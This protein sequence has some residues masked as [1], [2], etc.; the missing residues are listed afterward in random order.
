MP[1]KVLSPSAGQT[2]YRI[3]LWTTGTTPPSDVR[4]EGS[5]DAADLAYHWAS[6]F[7][8]E[9]IRQVRIRSFPREHHEL[10]TRDPEYGKPL[11]LII[12][13]TFSSFIWVEEFWDIVS[14]PTGP[15][16]FQILSILRSYG[17]YTR[18]KVYIY[19]NKNLFLKYYMY[20]YLFILMHSMAHSIKYPASSIYPHF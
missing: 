10:N 11:T 15:F 3:L 20:I 17:L 6:E 9:V 12:N 18:G 5:T 4:A 19:T 8:G 2:P 14:I 1:I 7:H 13:F 16:S